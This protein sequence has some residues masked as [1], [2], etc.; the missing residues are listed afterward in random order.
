MCNG[1]LKLNVKQNK[2]SL[3]FRETNIAQ[4]I[5]SYNST[6]IK[7]TTI[8]NL[9]INVYVTDSNRS[10]FSSKYTNI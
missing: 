1:L 7:T 4:I 3:V 2:Y 10:A 5:S 9:T 6:N 8:L